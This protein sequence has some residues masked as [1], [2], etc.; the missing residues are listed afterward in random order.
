MKKIFLLVIFYSTVTEF[1]FGAG[2]SDAVHMRISSK[3]YLTS[4]VDDVRQAILYRYCSLKGKT[5]FFLEL[6]RDYL[7]EKGI[8]VGLTY[9]D[10]KNKD[11]LKSKNEIEAFV[12]IIKLFQVLVEQQVSIQ[13]S[14]ITE[15]KEDCPEVDKKISVLNTFNKVIYLEDLLSIKTNLEKDVKKKQLALK[16]ILDSLDKQVKHEI[17]V[18]VH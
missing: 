7:S 11:I 2:F 6:I 16:S 5:P 9:K 13:E 18:D 8:K 17:L 14:K 12:L 15:L 4:D 3:V 1:L 10:F